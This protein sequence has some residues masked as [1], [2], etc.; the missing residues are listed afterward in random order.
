MI[1][2]ATPELMA[3]GALAAAVPIKKAGPETARPVAKHMPELATHT[4]TKGT[5]Q[6]TGKA[7]SRHF[8][9]LGCSLG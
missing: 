1:V 3:N 6:H 8:S 2:K 9:S 5:S 7:L 4:A